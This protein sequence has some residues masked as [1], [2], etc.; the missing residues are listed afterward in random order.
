MNEIFSRKVVK[1]E[2]GLVNNSVRFLKQSMVW[3]Q[4]GAEWYG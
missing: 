2:D 3:D 1:S 4:K